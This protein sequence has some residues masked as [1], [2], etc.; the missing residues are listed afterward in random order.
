MDIARTT[1]KRTL[2]STALL[3]LLAAAGC[4]PAPAPE[5]TAAMPP[6]T[7]AVD[8]TLIEA[9]PPTTDTTATP[10]FDV[11]SLPVSEA[12]LGEFPYIGLPDGYQA[13]R[14][15][16]R[17]FDRVP[18]W[19]GD[20]VEWVEG[21]VHGTQVRAKDGHTF[22]Q[23]ELSRN[24]Q[25]LVESLGGK[26]IFTGNIPTR[27]LDDIRPSKAG[28]DWVDGLG[29]IY[30]D[31]ANVYVIH[32]ADRDI[33]I[34][35]AGSGAASGLLIAETRPVQITAKAMPADALKKSLDAD[36][37]VAIQVQFDTDKADIL[38]ASKPQLEQVVALLSD[39][40]TLRLAINGHTDNTGDAQ[41]N[42]QLS[43]RRAAAV[44]DFITAAKIDA[45]RLESNGFGDAQPVADNGNEEG[46][47]RN[48]RVELV[49]L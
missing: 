40:P 4:K 21:Q 17:K 49:K 6:E 13:D 27:G 20:R 23:M 24:V 9:A 29:D 14:P 47:A 32:R 45:K 38:P 19:T 44:R 7:P 15:T 42:L 12:A 41:H 28:V 16:T 31:P 33:W 26:E 43:Q 22:S 30:N 48:R 35:L 1:A 8:D 18:F 37:K 46:K 10:V 11:S 3:A 36:G 5:E 25:A 39:N 2:L 34:H